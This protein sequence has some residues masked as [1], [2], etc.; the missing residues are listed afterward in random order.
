MLPPWGENSQSASSLTNLAEASI[1]GPVP[2]LVGDI[3]RRQQRKRLRKRLLVLAGLLAAIA[4]AVASW[5]FF[6]AQ[7]RRVRLADTAEQFQRGTVPTLLQASDLLAG[8]RSRAANILEAEA[9]VKNQLWIEFGV[10]Q[11]AAQASV[12]ALDL[13]TVAYDGAV[14]IGL[15]HAAQGDLDPAE[16]ALSQAIDLA[17]T[18]SIAPGHHTYL[19]AVLALA[20][21]DAEALATVRTELKSRLAESPRAVALRRISIAAAVRADARDE[22]LAELDAAR[23]QHRDHMGL[24]ADEALYNASFRQHV[25]GVASVA[26]QLLAVGSDVPPRDRVH[27]E[28]ALAAAEAY[29][30]EFDQSLARLREVWP[31]LPKSD[32]VARELA[33]ELAILDGDGDL[34]REWIDASDLPQLEADLLRASIQVARGEIMESLEALAK[35]PQAHPRVAHLQGL[36]L[37]EQGRFAEAEPWLRRADELVPGQLDIEVAL[38]RVELRLHDA[39]AALRKLEGLSEEEALAPR[40]WTGLGEAY[41]AVA[42]RRNRDKDLLRAGQR[43]LEQGLERERVPAEAMLQLAVLHDRS[44]RRTPESPGKALELLEQAAQTNRHLPR[45][46]E[47]YG[48]YLAA[49]GYQ[50][51]ALSQLASLVDRRGIEPETVLIAI[52]LAI[53]LA[54][55]PDRPSDDELDAWFERAEE[56]SADPARLAHERARRLLAENSRGSSTKALEAMTA[57]IAKNPADVDARVLAAQASLALYE[58]KEAETVLRRGLSSVPDADRG[59]LYLQWAS[60]EARTG[61]RGKGAAHARVAWRLLS[62]SEAPPA[63]AL[64]AAALAVRLFIELD[65]PI[66]AFAVGRN[67]SEAMPYHPAAWVLR[68][69]GELAAKK[70][71]DALE[72]AKKAAE[73][74]PEDPHAHEMLGH[75]YMRFGHKD[76]A[77]AAYQ[78]A[79]ELATNPAM[80]KDLQDNLR[81]L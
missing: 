3:H 80:E 49:L 11:A 1:R 70:A 41:V 15:W 13:D 9:L 68:A 57:L 50:H 59:P 51:R 28:L 38:A 61:A 56:L 21:G 22:A 6:D 64:E 46:A 54:D 32:R 43:A 73:V 67:V 17:G 55:H 8:D 31:Q 74:G 16:A 72:H 44:R 66:P 25:G 53:E 71:P 30:G 42:E 12:D 23:E 27:A 69:R 26:E 58:R 52:R 5:R 39:D 7:A 40:V 81:R 19:E 47:H 10:D 77:K 20:S 78:R 24:A 62:E 14:A 60:I 2:D 76:D 35:L 45:Y 4:A 36:A 63:L 79:V 48:R 65:K 34:A 37:V 33:L 29:S 75:C 18:S